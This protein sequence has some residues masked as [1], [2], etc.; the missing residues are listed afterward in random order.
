M[1][2]VETININGVVFSIDDDAYGRLVAYLDALGKYFTN[3]QGGREIIADI[4]A[5]I[6][7]LFAE[8][9]GG[10]G[11]V[12]TLADVTRAVETLGTPEDIAGTDTDL[13][14]ENGIPP[15]QSERPVRRLYRDPDR[16]YLGGVCSGIAAWASINPIVIRLAFL[17][18]AFF[19]GASVVAYCILWIIIPKAKTTAQKLEMYGEPITISNIEKNIKKSLSDPSLQQSFRSFLN[20]ASE[21]IGKI[22]GAVWRI[23]SVLLGL[24]LCCAGI[25]ICIGIAWLFYM[26][27]FIFNHEVDWDL[28]S[29]NELL[30]HLISPASYIIL[31][32]CAIIVVVLLVL[33]CLFWGVR[34]ITGFKLKNKLLHVALSVVWI[35]AIVTGSIVCISQARSYAWSNEQLVETRQVTLSDTLYLNM[36]S[37]QMQLSNNPMEI[38]YDKTANRFYGK[39]NLSFRKSDDGQIRLRIRR[40]AQGENKRAAYQYAENIGY[41]VETRDSLLTFAPYFTV[42]PQDKWKFQT[43]GIVLYI[44]ENTV[45]IID[46]ALCNDRIL[47]ARFRW[48]SNDDCSWV[49]TDEKGLQPID[50]KK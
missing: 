30:P 37:S 18:A 31:V 2:R 3:E 38:Y 34:L 27:D 47:G 5:R 8:R 33:A 19:Y 25:G 13:G 32:I 11:Q 41:D 9:L 7:E 48:R 36:A 22:F 35:A 17:V 10:T 42:T 6:S 39:P 15:R 44:P 45:I 16:R 29:F 21:F 40:D 26:Q 14:D 4:E 20:E 49:M 1:K 24:F 12:V 46:K 50:S 23:F 43:L 28:L